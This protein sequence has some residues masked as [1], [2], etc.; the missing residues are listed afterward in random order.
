MLLISGRV[1][2]TGTDMI[3]RSETEP[4]A[5]SIGK[6]NKTSSHP[7]RGDQSGIATSRLQEKTHQNREHLKSPEPYLGVQ[8]SLLHAP[9]PNPLDYSPHPVS[10]SHSSHA[11]NPRESTS[12]YS[13]NLPHGY[14]P[15]QNSSQ[16]CG[17][18][19]SIHPASDPQVTCNAASSPS[20]PPGPLSRTEREGDKSQSS[21]DGK[22]R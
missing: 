11:S 14:Q 4:C 17:D 6:T 20:Q 5:T 12:T 2:A 19:S 8:R 13:C 18:Q 21:N 15:N 3:L 10:S 1:T 9:K 16:T 22:D 7:R